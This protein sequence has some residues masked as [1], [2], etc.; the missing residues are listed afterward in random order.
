VGVL[1]RWPR[2]RVLF[3]VAVVIAALSAAA[4]AVVLTK[5]EGTASAR[6]RANV[7]VVALPRAG[8][9]RRAAPNSLACRA[10]GKCR[11]FNFNETLDIMQTDYHAG[12]AVIVAWGDVPLS[13]AGLQPQVK[14]AAAV[15]AASL[16]CITIRFPD[17]GNMW[18][19]TTSPFGPRRQYGC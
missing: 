5:D 14:A 19:V 15:Y 17:P 6:P 3:A 7:Q 11:N 10:G 13:L 8:S 4:L 9:A 1:S 16:Y 18:F 12:R 2:T